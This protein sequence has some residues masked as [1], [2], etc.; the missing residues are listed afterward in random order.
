MME[1]RN[2]RSEQ[3]PVLHLS[4]V[5]HVCAVVFTSLS[6]STGG[7]DSTTIPDCFSSQQ[8]VRNPQTQ[9]NTAACFAFYF[10]MCY[11]SAYCAPTA[12]KKRNKS[13]SGS[14]WSVHLPPMCFSAGSAANTLNTITVP[15]WPLC[16]FEIHGK[17][18]CN[19][20]FLALSTFQCLY[21]RA[22]A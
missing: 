21:K 5:I 20:T 10:N 11:F 16:Y 8:A 12:P 7:D 4:L 9:G 15:S 1:G 3:R 2:R 19:S 14:H 6:V 18:E 22:T 13:T 17:I